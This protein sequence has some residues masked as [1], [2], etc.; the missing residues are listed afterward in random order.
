MLLRTLVGFII[1]MVLSQG[2]TFAKPVSGIFYQPLTRDQQ[3]TRAQWQRLL[4]A[5]KADGISHI[6][7]QWSE[8]EHVSFTGKN[9][10][11]DELIQLLQQR[12]ITWS[13]GLK[14]P[15]DYYAVMESNNTKEK[16]TK[17]AQ[18]LNQNRRQMM[19]LSTLGY[20]TKQG[21]VSWY[22]PLEVSEPYIE[23]A[24]LETW[25]SGIHALLNETEHSLVLSY[26]P[27]AYGVESAFK[28]FYTRL[29]HPQLKVMVQLS[30]GLI[31]VEQRLRNTSLPC[32]V[33]I[34]LENFLQISSPVQAFEA[35][36]HP[37]PSLDSTY[38]CHDR[39]IFSLRYQPYSRYLPLYD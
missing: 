34:I 27:S 37:I 35:Q 19:R 30:N 5:L 8:Y 33:G 20:P 9:Q 2:N 31:D 4:L 13:L 3:V 25:Q 36:R 39:Y 23:G 12:G 11:I 29:K 32:D 1:L 21:F 7:L 22:L 38:D 24:L 15:Q 14:L 10:L 26:F 6:I 18:W 17:L 28:Q 16:Q